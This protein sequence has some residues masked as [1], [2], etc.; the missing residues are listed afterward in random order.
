MN[1]LITFFVRLLE[2]MFVIGVIGCVSSVIPIT[3]Y[4]LFMVLFEPEDPKEELLSIQNQPSSA[5]APIP[6][7]PKEQSAQSLEAAHRQ[8]TAPLP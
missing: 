8:L 6:Q 4:R 5:P 7:Q 2:A 3:A 1:T